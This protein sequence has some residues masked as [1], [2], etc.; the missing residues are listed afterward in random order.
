MKENCLFA[1]ALLSLALAG[2]CAKGGN[3]IVPPQPSIDVEISSPTSVSSLAIYPTQSLTLTATVS[4]STTTAVTWSLTGPSGTT[5]TGTPNPCGTL[6]PVTPAPTPATATYVAPATPISGVTVTATLVSDTSITGSLPLDVVDITTDVAP[7][8]LSVGSGLTQQFTAVAV[9]DDA[10]QT[11][12]WSCSANGNQC[13]NFVQD[14]NVSGLAYY[15]ANDNCSGSCVQ[16]SAA[17]TPQD[18]N[19]CSA[20]PKYCTIAKVSLVTSRLSVN[21]TYAFQFSGYD[22]SQHPVMVAGIFAT[23]K[24]GA[25]VS[26]VEDV[27]TG[28]G[29][30]TQNP[31]PITGGSYIPTSAD[32]N[33]SNNAGTLTLTLPAGVYPNQFQVVLDGAG[34]LEM[35]ESDSQGTGSGIA[36]KSSY[37]L[38]TGL[39]DQTYAF[40]FTGVDSGGNRVGYVGVLP[41]N[42]TSIAGAQVDVNDNATANTYS[43]LTA[44][45]TPDSN[46]NGLWHVTGLTLASGTTLDFDFFV[47][48]GTTGKTNPLTFYA[49]STDTVGPTHPAAVSGTMILQDSTQTY[50][51]AHFKSTSVSA[52]TGTGTTANGAAIPGTTNVSLTLGT[53]DG[54]GN[55]SGQF[56]QNNAGTILSGVQFPPLTGTNNYTYASSG[57]PN[58]NGRYTFNMLGNPGASPVVA[59]IPFVLYA[60]G[61]NRG[62]LLDQNSSSVMTGT[63]N[64]QGKIPCAGGICA[65]SASELPGTYA[66]ATTSSSAVSPIAA[67]LLATIQTTP[68]TLALT[69]NISGTQYPGGQTVT[70]TYSGLAYGDLGVFTVPLTAPSTQNYVIYVVDTSGCTNA[71]GPVCAVQD[72]LMIDEDKTNT[73]PSI[74]FAQQ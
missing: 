27:L 61:A 3:G 51:I 1:V 12:T 31:I 14:Q 24:T 17:Q 41:M 22:N 10:P 40:G 57:T 62:F 52:L 48:S 66:A 74:I 63:M 67:N 20:N 2:G 16:I 7:A 19:G 23:D 72:F 18:P 9:P 47:A 13:A 65:L 32:P 15:T 50:D 5:C 49:I 25:I 59:P 8:A 69:Y 44:N 33:N 71:S 29:P 28:S 42:G 37:K 36:Q 54:N 70:G 39:T 60:S 6:T 38:F 73:N 55:F 56:D 53:T 45:Y 34:D 35:I 4:N 30:S 11:F 21:S 64:P 43:N 46:I 26:G 68:V 58:N